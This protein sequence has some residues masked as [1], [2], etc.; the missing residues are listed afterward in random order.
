MFD[1]YD[2][3]VS[4]VD[5]ILVTIS[6]VLQFHLSSD[7]HC[8]F[9]RCLEGVADTARSCGGAA[10]VLSCTQIDSSLLDFTSG[11]N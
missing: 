10:I 2:K 9:T 3:E 6:Q 8:L 5:P 11:A 4:Q 7:P 1:A